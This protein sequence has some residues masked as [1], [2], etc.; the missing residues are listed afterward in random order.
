MRKFFLMMAAW[1][2]AVPVM[3]LLMLIA[4]RRDVM[5]KFVVTGPLFWLGWLSTA[6]MGFCVI[7]MALGFFL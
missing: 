3:V 2:L 6:A 5:S 1:L 4:R 7:V